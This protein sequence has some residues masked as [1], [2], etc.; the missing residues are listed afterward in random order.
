MIR[1]HKIRS[2]GIILVLAML[3]PGAGGDAAPKKKA[4]LQPKQKQQNNYGTVPR[5]RVLKEFKEAYQVPPASKVVQSYHTGRIRNHKESRG[6]Q[7]IPAQTH[8]VAVVLQLTDCGIKV[9]YLWEVSYYKLET[10]WIF[11]DIKQIQSKQLTWPKKKHPLLDKSEIKKILAEGLPNQYAGAE[12]QDVTVLQ[13][14]PTWRLCEPEFQVTSKVALTLKN[15]VY[16]RQTGYECIF[17]TTVA[18]RN[19][20]WTHV[21]SGCAYKGKLIPDCHIGTMCRELSVESTLPRISDAEAVTQLR[22]AFEGVYGLKKNNMSVET[23][24]L[25]GKQAPEDFGKKI[26]C[27][28]HAVFTM[29]E[30][31]EIKNNGSP[32]IAVVRAVYECEVYGYL[33]YSI[34]EKTWEGVIES[35]CSNDRENCGLSCSYPNK[36]CKR[37]GEK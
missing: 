7:K 34:D 5:N 15:D 2:T 26:R 19:G 6:D 17:T 36:G 30:E 37:L 20:A 25:T 29:D 32:T 1:H 27:A 18:Q 3:M 21:Q 22:A 14:K 13:I 8:R 4:A 11:Q 24:T 9:R 35:C 12:I 10:E 28:M 31:K 23:F 33:R 16:N